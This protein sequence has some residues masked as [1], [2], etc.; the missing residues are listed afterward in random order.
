[1]FS[2]TSKDAAI[3]LMNVR[4]IAIDEVRSESP[5]YFSSYPVSPRTSSVPSLTCEGDSPTLIKSLSY[6]VIEASP[7]AKM[8]RTISSSRF[9]TVSVCSSSEVEE[10]LMPTCTA[11]NVHVRRVSIL[12]SRSAHVKE[13]KL[14]E[15]EVR[16]G[17]DEYLS[18]SSESTADIKQTKTIRSVLSTNPSS[19]FVLSRVDGTNKVKDVLR[20]KFSWKSFP[21]LEQYLIDNRS[22]YLQFSNQLN[23]TAE[24]KRYNNKLTQGLLDLASEEGYVFEGFTFAAVRDRIRC[25][26]KSYVQATKKKKLK[27]K[28][29]STK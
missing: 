1:M 23:Y 8:F 3:L 7:P 16:N 9:R 12:H 13:D 6:N 27:T 18:D 22:Q 19:K 5:P 21:E 28:R 29:P 25:Y 26:Y 15:D 24:Q 14:L 20:K 11:S 2:T 17:V 4:K 10:V